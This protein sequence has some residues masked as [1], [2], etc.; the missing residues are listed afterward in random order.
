MEKNIITMWAILALFMVLAILS[1]TTD[2][3]DPDPLQDFCV[4]T[5]VPEFEVFV[6]GKFCKNPKKVTADDFFYKGFNI[7][8]E[9][10]IPQGAVVTMVNYKN[11]PGL[12]TQGI[13][14]ARADYAPFG[15]NAPHEHPRAT[16]VF[17]VV[18]GSFYAGFVTTDNKL[19]D[20]ILNEGDAMVFPRSLYH[21]QLNLGDTNA[22][23]FVAFNSQ[24]PARADVARGVFGAKGVFGTTPKIYDDV[25]S[26]TFLVD[27]T[28]I[29]QIQS[30]IL[31]IN[32]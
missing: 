24:N 3:S 29:E 30:Q 7:P 32:V 4:A 5:E 19:Y 9:I 1:F 28:V 2:A 25:L 11:L 26:K 17:A 14:I 21:F 22:F 6:N 16:E 8:G 20:K 27:K 13:S 23:A 12:N 10:K 18:K 15:V 31:S